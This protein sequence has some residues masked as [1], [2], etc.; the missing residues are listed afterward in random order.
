MM[1]KACR[2]V[3]LMLALLSGCAD[4]VS[5]NGGDG[6]GG[7]SGK[8]DGDS[9]GDR[10]LTAQWQIRD[11]GAQF[12]AACPQGFDTVAVTSQ[13]IDSH[14]GDVGAPSIDLF[15]CAAFEGEATLPAGRYRVAVDVTT[16]NGSSTYASST[17]AIVDL[18]EADKLADFSIFRDGGYFSVAWNLVGGSSNDPLDCDQV[19]GLDGV[20]LVATLATTTT[21]TSDIWTCEDK[22]GVTGV[23]AAGSYTVSIDAINDTS[24]ALGTAPALTDRVI[25]PLNKITHLGTVTIPVDGM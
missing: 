10:T 20:E 23:L 8:A 21:A 6:D 25:Q 2:P 13:R 16:S 22:L 4:L 17:S 5:S 3:A 18:G 14:G 15:D 7:G 11:V 9:N 19:A 12:A 1:M 24:G